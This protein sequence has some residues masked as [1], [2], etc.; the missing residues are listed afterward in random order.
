MRKMK[1]CLAV[2]LVLCLLASLF[3]VNVFAETPAGEAAVRWLS[4]EEVEGLSRLDT[5]GDGTTGRPALYADD[6]LVT[7]IVQLED[8]PVMEYYG[9]STYAAE[10]EAGDATPG[11][12]VS[13]FLNSADAVELS[14]ELLAQQEDVV[15]RMDGDTEPEVVGQW[16]SV[17][18]AVAVKVPY[19]QFSAIQAMEGVKRAYVERTF[20]RPEEPVTEAGEIASYSYDMIG[21]QEVWGAGYTG[22]G[23]LVAVVDT[24]LDLNWQAY[25]DPHIV[26]VHEAFTDNSFKSEDAT[27]YLRYNSASLAAFLKDNTLNAE[28]RGGPTELTYDYNALYKN[29]KVPF[30]YDYADLDLNVLPS[31]S[32]HGTHVSGTIVGYSQTEEGVVEFSGV[33]PDAQLLS[34]KVF[35]DEGGGAKESDT[36]DAL[37][38]AMKLGADVINLSLGSDNGFAEDDTAQEELYDTI[39]AA[40]ILLMTS[41]GNSNNSADNNNY[42]GYNL[43]SNP[44]ISMMSS[45][46]VYDSNLAV[47]SINNTVQVETVFTWTD[48]DGQEHE[49]VYIDPTGVAMKYKFVGEEPV[50][51]VPVGGVGT[52]N[53]YYNA[54]F[55]S[56]YGY[57][58]E[59]GVSGIALV[60]RGEISFV[61][62][63]NNASSFMS[64]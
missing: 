20:E 59:K 34:L 51:I 2:F 62:K 56:Y 45:P 49:V 28:F 39:R 40:G 32:D 5:T 46:A 8:A 53:D 3:T 55:R 7:V 27:S 29:L 52:Y 64:S 13:E 15:D 9:M 44:E 10:A 16:T 48:K 1:R 12:A 30:A 24:G 43:A 42:Y 63:I 61:D 4:A 25:A 22:K 26:S 58:G 37:E 38:D 21:I 11:E 18:N 47:A 19:G 35:S 31:D 54:G 23:M 57:G 60:Q 41:A 36:M 17:I 33:A 14:E 50:S 6:E